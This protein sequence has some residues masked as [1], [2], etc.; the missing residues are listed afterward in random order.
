MQ[1]KCYE[2]LIQAEASK[3]LSVYRNNNKCS[4]MISQGFR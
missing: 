1:V 4:M 3:D 2:M